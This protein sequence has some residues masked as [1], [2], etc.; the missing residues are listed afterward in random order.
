MLDSKD[1]VRLIGVMNGKCYNENSTYIMTYILKELFFVLILYKCI[2]L[3][4]QPQHHEKAQSSC[5]KNC[6]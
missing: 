1:D 6:V 2:T 5:I 3:L 4:R